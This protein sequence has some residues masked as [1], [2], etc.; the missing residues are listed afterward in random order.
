MN[1]KSN[2]R[3]YVT[4]SVLELIRKHPERDPQE[5][6]SNFIERMIKRRKK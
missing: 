4:E 6:D 5:R 2:K 3:I 1:E